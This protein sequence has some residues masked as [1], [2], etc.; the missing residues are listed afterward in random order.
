FWCRLPMVSGPPRGAI[1]VKFDQASVV[2]FFVAFFVAWAAG[3]GVGLFVS[4]WRGLFGDMS[5]PD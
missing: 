3:Y 5:N 2:T 1:A 4:W